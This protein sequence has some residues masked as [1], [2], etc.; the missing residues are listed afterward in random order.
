MRSDEPFTVRTVA[1]TTLLAIF[2][3]AG[4]YWGNISGIV[5]AWL[6]ASGVNIILFAL[7]GITL[8]IKSRSTV[9]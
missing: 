2:V 8:Q 7:A 5:E 6:I 1:V 9:T 3:F 4:L